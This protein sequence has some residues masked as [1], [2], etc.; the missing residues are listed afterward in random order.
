[1]KAALVGMAWLVASCACGAD[2]RAL[3]VAGLGGSEEFEIAF[4]RQ[5][6]HAADALR[7]VAGDVTLLLG[8]MVSEQRLGE[9]IAELGSR[10]T[11]SDTVLL[12]LI[13]HGTF[14][15][16]DYRFNVPGPDVTGGE[17]SQWLDALHVERQLVVVA[18]SASG[19][20]QAR[21]ARPQRTVM[22]ATKSGAENNASVFAGHF[23]AALAAAEADLDKDG[24]VSATEAF[25]YAENQ[26]AAHYARSR[27]MASEHPL[28]RGPTATVR[29]A[30]LDEGAVFEPE[31]R[32]ASRRVAE[33]EAAVDAL[34]ADKA[35]RDSDSYYAELQ[36]LLLDLALA[37]RRTGSEEMP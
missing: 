21:L 15:D 24:Y 30:R 5:A 6:K 19:A 28:S 36:R 1:M 16:R 32:A 9:E 23:V 12:L 31:S 18:T 10:A 20:L 17:L 7:A 14:D 25:G 2:T 29:L 3:V 33:L 34:R 37:R 35:N 11:P 27:Q 13:G 4:Q 8:D 26:V 22:T